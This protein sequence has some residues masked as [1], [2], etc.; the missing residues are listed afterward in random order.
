MQYFQGF[1]WWTHKGS[2]LG[3]S[4]VKVEVSEYP[5]DLAR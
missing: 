5:D 2:N 1:L 3:L 4:R